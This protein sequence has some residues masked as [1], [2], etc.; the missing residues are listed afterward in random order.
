[1]SCRQILPGRRWCRLRPFLVV[2]VLGACLFY[3]TLTPLKTRRYLSPTGNG[4]LI[5]KVVEVQQGTYKE[6][7]KRQ[8]QCFLPSNDLQA[9][10]EIKDA[11]FK[12]FGS[13]T[14]TG[15]LYIL[16]SG[17][18]QDLKLYQHILAQ[19][20]YEVTV[21]E[22]SKLSRY[23]IPNQELSSWDLLICLSSRKADHEN[24]LSIMESHRPTL[25][26]KANALPWI[27]HLL[28]KKEGLCQIERT[29]PGLHLPIALPACPES[30]I[31]PLHTVKPQDNY[32]GT[33][34]T[35][36][37]YQPIKKAQQHQIPI[38]VDN[39]GAFKI[40]DLSVIIKVYVLVTSLTPLR[41]FIHST[42]VVLYAPKKKHFSVK[43]QA[44]FENF[45]T[46]SS[47]Q[48]ALDDM[49][50][51]I[52][53]LLLITE[54]FSEAASS[55]PKASSQCS[56]CFQMLTFDIGFSSSMHPVVL[57]VH[58]H[59]DVPIDE[60]PT[61]QDQT[62][63]ESILR[64]T[65]GIIISNQS[66]STAFFK[67]LQN[68][69]RTAGIKNK[70][71]QKEL[72]H[73]LTLEELNP[74]IN[75]AQEFQNL[76]QFEVL[77]PSTAPK[78]HFL[79]HEL[80]RMANVGEN[81]DS[82]LTVHWLLSNLLEQLQVI[83]R[84]A[85]TNQLGRLNKNFG[86]ASWIKARWSRLRSSYSEK[87]SIKTEVYSPVS[88]KHEGLHFFNLAKEIHCS[89]D[90]DTLPHIKQ[91]FT[92]PH[93]DLNPVFD[94]KIKEYYAEVPFD[95]V[96]IM[97]K[98]EPVHCQCEVHLD[99]KNGPSAANYPLG[100]GI[101]RVNILVTDVSQS[102]HEVVSIYRIIVFR[103][104][105]PSLPLFDDFMV[106]GFV[107][108]CGLIIHPEEPCGLKPISADYLS[109]IS[110]PQLKAC[111][112]GDIKGQ[113]IVP[114]L[115]CSDNRTC[116]WR[117]ITWQPHNC[118]YP[119]L[120][121]PE[122]QQCVENKKV[123]FIG[124]STNRGMMY[125]LIERMNKTLQE[126]QKAH[127]VKFYDN[128]NDR[129][130]FISY[131]YY[132]QFWISVN[133]RP[134]FEEALEELLL[135]SQPLRNTGQT[136]LVVGGVQWLNFNHL[137]II[138]RVLK[139][140]NLSNI[141]VVIKSLGMGFHLPVDGVH[142][143]SPMEVQNLWNENQAILTT[144]KRYG[145]EVVDTFIITMGRYKEFLQGKCG[146]HFHEVVKSKTSEESS[147]MAMSF[148]KPYTLGKYFNKQS[149][150]VKLQAYASNSQS[151]Y[152]VRGPINQVYSEILL[153]R[154]C[155]NDRKVAGL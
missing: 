134:T 78:S 77:F 93:L 110:Q 149:N 137:H 129:R 21:L 44:F 140:A 66:S 1:M 94:P 87:D 73:C 27:Q 76:G 104:D 14:R 83:N 36:M 50:D 15:I 33:R 79:L 131:S 17:S 151:P 152:H 112:A 72:G 135:R 122:L 100:L 123:L 128:V 124:D 150:L 85:H 155:A 9:Q 70:L 8:V 60:D 71:H 63:K 47:P 51:A 136:I 2:L 141:Q 32:E 147:S 6:V 125:Y 88:E 89:H 142:Y 118:Q 108:D 132:P 101:N 117:Q 5:N 30:N 98:A 46:T 22:D 3:Q 84:V 139:R 127:D 31:V 113:W 59:F 34:L 41:A 96:T 7:S 40:Q 18:K 81:L 57:E 111:E 24:C 26:Q 37:F 52:S 16:P 55:G 103:E 28:C 133:Q 13:Q 49:K 90:K 120:S 144:A 20:Q 143:L 74:L 38:E 53:K 99:E 107:Q 148:S 138:Q 82:V 105:R 10:K 62:V 95:V 4:V 43:L 35:Q 145:Y 48:Q 11:I 56:S 61:F 146:C 130:T 54:V 19:H 116:D 75:F 119:V 58:E 106:C 25:L 121:K 153:S 39:K 42:G 92:T 115:S 29:F 23:E 102:V 68:V 80:Y 69:Y 114:C 45:F 109:T 91:I 65:F 97:I 154:I 86:N 67:A 12:Y 126:W 64:D